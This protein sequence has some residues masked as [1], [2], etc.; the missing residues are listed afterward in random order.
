MQ[1]TMQ[2]QQQQQQQLLQAFNMHKQNQSST[3][4]SQIDRG[5]AGGVVRK[6]GTASLWNMAS[7]EFVIISSFLSRPLSLI[8]SVW[9]HYRNVDIL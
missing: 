1:N 2:Q 3:R 9:A 4:G 8:L 7:H 5:G 6:G